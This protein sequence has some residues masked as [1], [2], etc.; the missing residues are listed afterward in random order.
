MDHATPAGAE[1]PAA[2]GTDSDQTLETTQTGALPTDNELRGARL[3]SAR[4]SGALT[5]VSHEGLN[6]HQQRELRNLGLLTSPMTSDAEVAHEKENM[7]EYALV[8]ET[9]H[10][11]DGV[12]EHGME[13][14]IDYAVATGNPSLSTV[15]MGRSLPSRTHSRRRWNRHK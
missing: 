2:E 6:P 10:R 8:A 4:A 5:P 11:S 13:V 1:E 3:M 15:R 7:V 9:E 12:R 14:Y